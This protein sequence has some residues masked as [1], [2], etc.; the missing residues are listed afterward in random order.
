[1]NFDE[2]Q[3]YITKFVT[4]ELKDHTEVSGYISNP[5]EVVHGTASDL[6]LVNGLQSS[7][8]PVI[9]IIDIREAVRE[10]TTEIPILGESINLKRKQSF[11]DRLD[12]LLDKSLSETLEVKL[13]NGKI[14]DN[15]GTKK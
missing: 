9:N 14:I 2:L 3:K 1:M 12:E 15:S 6:V 5:R 13:P 10:D 7:Q 8:I 4:V 11:D